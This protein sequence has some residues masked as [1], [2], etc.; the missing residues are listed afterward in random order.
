MSFRPD[1]VID[2]D[3][4]AEPGIQRD[5]R[6]CKAERGSI[7]VALVR[8]PAGFNA[9]VPTLRDSIGV[10]SQT[11]SAYGGEASYLF[12]LYI[13]ETAEPGPSRFDFTTSSKT[14]G[15]AETKTA[16]GTIDVSGGP[17]DPQPLPLR[18]QRRDAVSG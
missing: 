1:L 15:I 18:V 10:V 6:N 9:P 16:S 14:I 12:M 11:G 7:V 13:P 4:P 2:F 3:Q 17:G 5:R 8:P